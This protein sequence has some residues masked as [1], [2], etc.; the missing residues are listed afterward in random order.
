V[1]DATKHTAFYL[2]D[3]AFSPAGIAVLKCSVAYVLGCMPTLVPAVSKLLGT[4]DGKH[5]VATVVV[6]FHPARNAGSM[7]EASLLAFGAFIYAGLISFASMGV[8]VFFGRQ[9]LIWLG[10]LVV[11]VVF[12]GGGLGFIGW[13]KQRL[14]NPLVNVACSLAS[15]AII[16]V[17]TRE[18]AIHLAEFSYASVVHVLYMVLMGV[19]ISSLV[20]FTITPRSA[21]KEL[22]EDLIKIT[23]HM[24]VFLTFITRGFLSGSNEDC[25]NEFIEFTQKKYNTLFT[26]LAR[27]LREAKYEHYIMGTEKIHELEVKLVKCIEHLA[28]QSVLTNQYNNKKRIP[29]P[30]QGIFIMHT[31]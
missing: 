30:C 26:S 9:D 23:D 10:H 14:G 1:V 12:C 17:L 28:H 31:T 20:S 3:V 25:N 18:D 7:I 8:S 22:K 4:G 29:S 15:L 13:L 19:F 11:L 16:T 6:Y 21:R 2:W 5:L 27:N 24:E